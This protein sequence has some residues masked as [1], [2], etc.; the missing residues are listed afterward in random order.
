MSHQ[1]RRDKAVNGVC[2]GGADV[3]WF[4]P[5]QRGALMVRAWG[6]RTENRAEAQPAELA[7]SA[8]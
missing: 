8:T 6:T 5:P 1:G 7:L 3:I 2:S 4:Y